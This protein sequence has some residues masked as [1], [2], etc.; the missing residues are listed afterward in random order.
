MR[1]LGPS[2]VS[3]LAE[4]F[5]NIISQAIREAALVHRLRAPANHGKFLRL[6][7]PEQLRLAAVEV[8]AAAQ[9]AAVG[10][11]PDVFL[12]SNSAIEFLFLLWNFGL[13]LCRH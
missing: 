8:Q 1:L 12:V 13:I 6:R 5:G 7:R 9:I 10:S 2:L 3:Y 11:R 4:K